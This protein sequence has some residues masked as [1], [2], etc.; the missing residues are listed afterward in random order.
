MNKI[1]DS[2]SLFVA[3]I[4]RTNPFNKLMDKSSVY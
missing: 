3:G 1:V 2:H 4:G